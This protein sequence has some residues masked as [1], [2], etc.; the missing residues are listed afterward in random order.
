MATMASFVLADGQ[1]TPT[2]HTFVPVS[3]Y[4]GLFVWEEKNVDA[5][6]GN[7]KITMSLRNPQGKPAVYKAII[8]IWNP[9]LDVTSPSTAT[10]YQPAPRVAYSLSSTHEVLIPERSALADRKDSTAFAKNLYA[11]SVLTDLLNELVTP[12]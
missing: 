5:A 11:Q 8:K 12:I 2:N 7:R 1:T 9:K 10:G 3:N 6:V 4:N